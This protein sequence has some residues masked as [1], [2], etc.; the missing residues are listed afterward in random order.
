[1]T[2][3]LQSD[4]ELTVSMTVHPLTCDT[5]ICKKDV[6]SGFGKKK[7]NK[8]GLQLAAV[9]VRVT[10]LEMTVMVHLPKTLIGLS[11]KGF[12][13]Q[14]VRRTTSQVKNQNTIEKIVG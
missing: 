8:Q 3:L 5:V 12:T 4:R 13:I 11:K 10:E 7:S 2:K 14:Q 1:M 9:A 6:W